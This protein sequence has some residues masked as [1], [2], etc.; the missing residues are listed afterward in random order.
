MYRI[1]VLLVFLGSFLGITAQEMEWDRV[2]TEETKEKVLKVNWETSYKKALKKA[3]KENKPV[4]IYFSG[5]D[6]CG[7]CIKL[8][9]ELFHTEKFVDY[10]NKNMVLYLANF[11]R[12][13][14]LVTEEAKKDNKMLA[15]KFNN[16]FPMLLFVDKNGKKIEEKRG[17]YMSEYY[18]P[19]FESIIAKYY[20]VSK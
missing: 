5:S 17:V 18:F 15:K 13:K 10:A 16:S 2:E 14:D 12:N 7:P 8:D 3:E 4:L 20:T 19:F 1:V 9:K 11:P 6:W